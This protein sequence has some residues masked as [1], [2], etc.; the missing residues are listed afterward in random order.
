MQRDDIK[1][2]IRRR[3]RQILVHSCLYYRLSE[4]LVPDHVYDGWARELAVLHEKYPDIASTV[5]YHEY[6]QDFTSETVSG[7]DLPV[8]L[9]EIIAIAHSLLKYHKQ[10]K[11]STKR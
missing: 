10:L 3:R 5:E 4:T 2:L 11:A 8:H 6:F 7:F 9:P 1:S